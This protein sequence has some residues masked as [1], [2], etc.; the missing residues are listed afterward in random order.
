MLDY[1]E[2]KN[3]MP[4]KLMKILG[5]ETTKPYRNV[6]AMDARQIKFFGIINNLV[7]RMASH[8]DIMILMDI[9]VIDILD[10]LSVGFSSTKP[11]KTQKNLF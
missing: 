7:V 5:L 2:L 9:V 8:M 3:V 4:I 6:C 10:S 1:R 11:Y